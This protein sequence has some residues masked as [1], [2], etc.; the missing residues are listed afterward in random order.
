MK[1]VVV[2]KESRFDLL[3]GELIK[4]KNKDQYFGSYYTNR[5]NLIKHFKE[6]DKE[7]VIRITKEILKN[8][9]EAKN[10]QYAPCTVECKSWPIPAP[11]PAL[12][13]SLGIN[14]NQVCEECGL[15]KRVKYDNFNTPPDFKLTNFIITDS[16]EQEPLVLEVKTKIA[17]LNFGDYALSENLDNTLVIERKSASD[18]ISTVSRSLER[19]CRELL[20]GEKTN[21]NILIIVDQKLTNMLSF[22]YLPQFRWIRAQPSFFF[23]RLR[24]ILQ[25]FVNVQV[26]FLEN[27]KEMSKMTRFALSYGKSLFKYDVQHLYETNQLKP[28]LS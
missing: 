5:K 11:S 4:F 15:K 21:S 23:S 1:K 25:S 10:I 13:S 27:K 17:A 8:R 26:V 12:L 7:E 6:I 3:T 2:V 16:R 19:F 9:I 18:M 20:R 28:F 22:N 14:Y 24:E